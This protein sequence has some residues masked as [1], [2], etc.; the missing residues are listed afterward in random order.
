MNLLKIVIGSFLLIFISS[1]STKMLLKKA[2][3]LYDSGRYSKSEEIYKKAYKSCKDKP[4]RA[5]IALKAAKCFDNINQSGKASSW[6]RRAINNNDS[7][8][9]A[10]LKLARAQV[11][12][13]KISKAKESMKK[14]KLFAKEDIHDVSFISRLEKYSENRTRYMIREA[15]EFNSS[16][17]DFS[18]RYV[19][20]D[21]NIIVVSSARLSKFSKKTDPVTG[22]YYSNLYI[23]NYSNER[24]KITKLKKG[25]EK[26]TVIISDEFK[27]NKLKSI[28]DSLNSFYDD[29]VV[30]FNSSGSEMY[31]SSS[32]KILKANQGSKIY[33]V[34]GSGLKWGSPKMV[35]IVGDS[36]SVGHPALSDDGNTLYFASDMPGGLGGNDI[37]K[38]KKIKEGW[39]EPENMG[40]TINTSGNEVFPFIRENGELYFSSDQHN[41]IGGL[42]IFKATKNTKGAWEVENI[43]MP[44]NSYADDFGISFVP[45]E[46][47]GLFCSSRKK[48]DDNIY[49]FSLFVPQYIYV[50]KILDEDGDKPLA[51]VRLRLI[52]SDGDKLITQ[53]NEKGEFTLKIKENTEYI[54]LATK[55]D[56]LNGKDKISTLGL[57]DG[58]LIET[59]IKLK[60]ISKP[61]ELPNILYDFGK[62][63]LRIESEKS[64][65]ILVE[66][67]N[68]NP[69][70]TIELMSHTDYVGS[71]EKNQEISQ[72]RAQSVVD[73]LIQKNIRADRLTAVGKGESQPQVANNKLASKYNYIAE[74]DVLNKKFIKKHSKAQQ[75]S[76]NQINR[77][78]DFKVLR[79][80]YFPS[81]KKP[82]TLNAKHDKSNSA[83]KPIIKT[84]HF[85]KMKLNF[86]TIHLGNF[87]DE[88]I[89][90]SFNGFKLILKEKLSNGM[91]SYT[92]DFFLNTKAAN[93]RLAEI[94]RLGIKA[95][96]V[97]YK[98]GKKD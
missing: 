10:Y 68:D 41:G 91:F 75:E 24:V 1:C 84:A 5:T 17:S 20:G 23:T 53:T 25:E 77:R 95:S 57:K 90:D 29:G 52:S 67:L 58:K 74:G 27:W 92:T 38:V 97:A 76:L 78:T 43:K 36:V 2:N 14:Y 69:K 12:V 93:R 37:W 13:N 83:H 22:K 44:I 55:E 19:G 39:S 26:R 4:L 70:I 6:Y 48:N 50:G 79:T 40:K 59:N 88:K 9:M 85:D 86:Y 51:N 82:E 64:L 96:V 21:T 80:D 87:S 16:K 62:W 61:I 72:K 94:K 63:E 30:C 11:E 7:I 18:A 49:R 42:D 81:V 71:E 98:N 73:Y 8:S 65:D 47:K 34:K 3:A 56:Y 45:G 66:T 28:G 33:S 35:K 89:P 60:P 54:V 32:R 46:D 31:F 15:T